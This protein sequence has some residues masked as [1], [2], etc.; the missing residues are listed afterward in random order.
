MKEEITSLMSKS[1]NTSQKV[2]TSL[3][4]TR[5]DFIDKYHSLE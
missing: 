2:D 4:E 1:E 5:K 3:E